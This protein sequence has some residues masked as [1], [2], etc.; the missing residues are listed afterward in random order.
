MVKKCNLF[1]CN[2]ALALVESTGGG[3]LI[4]AS[5]TSSFDHKIFLRH[6]Q[7][8]IYRDTDSKTIKL[9]CRRIF[10]E[11]RRIESES[12]WSKKICCWRR[13]DQ[14]FPNYSNQCSK[15]LKIKPRVWRVWFTESGGRQPFQL[16]LSTTAT[17]KGVQCQTSSR[18]IPFWI[19]GCGYTRLV[20]T[21]VIDMLHYI[22]V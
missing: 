21:S 17:L 16:K 5:F 12:A 19:A 4:K 7:Q 22:L 2:A 3:E 6:S 10:L 11:Y 13:Q 8:Q 1:V 15:K 20:I 9:E 14:S 18:S